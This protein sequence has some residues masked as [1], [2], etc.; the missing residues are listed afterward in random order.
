M[1]NEEHKTVTD[2]ENLIKNAAKT[3]EISLNITYIQ[4]DILEI[5]QQLKEQGGSSV[6]MRDFQEH[7]RNGKDHETRIRVL[8][9]SMWKQ[10][11]MSSVISSVIAVVITI[12]IKYFLK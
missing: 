11:G 8:E 9:Q 2:A 6:T 5:K 7:L 3:A 10:V 1:N 12:L 4:R